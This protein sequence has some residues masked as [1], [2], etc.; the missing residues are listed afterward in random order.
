MTDWDSEQICLASKSPEQPLRKLPPCRIN[1]TK[2]TRADDFRCTS[3]IA[4][5]YWC[6]ILSICLADTLLMSFFTYL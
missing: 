5:S 4:M 6:L 3:L 2:W 1:S